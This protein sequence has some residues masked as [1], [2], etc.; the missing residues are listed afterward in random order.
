MGGGGGVRRSRVRPSPTAAGVI[1]ARATCARAS[2]VGG[3]PCCFFRR[4]PVRPVLVGRGSMV[5]LRGQYSV[6]RVSPGRYPRRLLFRPLLC[7]RPFSP[8][9]VARWCV[10]PSMWTVDRSV[11][12]VT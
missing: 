7:T 4:L 11:D 12:L 1:R 6:S 8:L 9:R 3:N 2:Q 10:C 5:S